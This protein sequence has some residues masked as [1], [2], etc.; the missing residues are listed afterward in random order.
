MPLGGGLR[1]E[2]GFLL[3]DGGSQLVCKRQRNL[4]QMVCVSSEMY[5][6]THVV[7]QQREHMLYF[8]T[9]WC[10][11]EAIPS[12]TDGRSTKSTDLQVEAERFYT[13]Y[14]SG[15]T[16]GQTPLFGGSVKVNLKSRIV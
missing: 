3:G 7:F 15:R 1:L 16:V 9:T 12:A 4:Q 14:K 8:S 6:S 5:F 11:S 2:F 13:W 10:I